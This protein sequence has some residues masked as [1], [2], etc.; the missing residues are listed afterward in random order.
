MDMFNTPIISRKI[1]KRIWAHKY[2]NGCININGTRFMFYTMTEA[3]K[4]WQNNNKL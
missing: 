4:I 3:I 1:R 2:L